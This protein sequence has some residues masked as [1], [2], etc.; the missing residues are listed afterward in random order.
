MQV[1]SVAAPTAPEYLPA[2]QS[3]HVKDPAVSAYVPSTQ[4]M[5]ESILVEPNAFEY[6]P[7][8]QSVQTPTDTLTLYFPTAHEMHSYP[9]NGLVYPA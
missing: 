3:L 5:Q 6:F 7:T 9:C 1:L 4:L 2:A 8:L